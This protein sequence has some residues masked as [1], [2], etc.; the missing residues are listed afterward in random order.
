[1]DRRSFLKVGLGTAFSLWAAPRLA[2]ASMPQ[3]KAR[4][5]IVLW[6]NGGPSH[7]DTFDPKPGA[8]TKSIATAAPAIQ[9]AEHLPQLAAAANHLCIL[10]G[11]T[12]KEGN[13]DRAR[14]LLHTG[15]VPNP[16]VAHPSLGGWVSEE[17]GDARS[18]L[19][20]FVSVSGPSA[21]AGFLGVEH[22]PFVVLDPGEP[23]A[24]TGYPH[25]VDMVRFVRRKAALDAMEADFAAATHDPKVAQ[26][27]AVYQKAV[28]MMYAPRLKAFGLGDEPEATRAAYG[29]SDFGRGC[30]LARRLVE[31]GVPFVEVTLDGWDTHQDNFGRTR[32]LM[33]Q[34]DPAFAALIGDLD[35][36]KLLDSTLIACLGEFGRTP[37]V[38]ENE[39]RDH[40]PKA[41]SAVLAGGGVRG[42]L[43]HG[44]TDG[45]GGTVADKP[46]AVPDLFA[47]LATQ[48]GIDPDKTLATP[49]GRPL[50]VTD[51][52]KPIREILN[53]R[54]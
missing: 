11:M 26:R 1:M 33:Q 54:S 46:T 52:G 8:P 34:L 13:H 48:L 40:Y 24:N 25:D 22:D 9:L 7:V 42:G 53:E 16:T 18:E 10:R 31:A 5:C 29:D 23:P 30:L 14:H 12:S 37:R 28:R 50:A 36:R 19:P 44:A 4:A 32:R 41:W 45:D 35:A 2:R 39:G 43:V 38:N 6:M 15:Y 49:L 21:R 3:R 17:L 51:N 20:T 47:T 27:R